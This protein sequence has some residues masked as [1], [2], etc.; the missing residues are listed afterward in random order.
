MALSAREPC[1]PNLTPANPETAQGI[2]AIA[3]YEPDNLA[4]AAALLRMGED[5]AARFL[6]D[7]AEA[8]EAETCQLALRGDLLE[9]KAR[10]LAHKLLDRMAADVDSLDALDAA[11]LIKHP[12]R[13][14]ENADRVR[15]AS[16]DPNANLAVF[17]FTF[18]APTGE[19]TATITPAKDPDVLDVEAK[20]VNGKGLHDE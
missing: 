6:M 17:N 1:V 5:D 16:K 12:L 10:R 13:I 14:I 7:H 11:D 3:K 8:I 4:Q 20:E 2:S 9:P 19:I 18:H 15:L